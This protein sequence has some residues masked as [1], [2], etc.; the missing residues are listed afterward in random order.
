MRHWMVMLVWMMGCGGE[1]EGDPEPLLEEP[2]ASEEPVDEAPEG[3]SESPEPESNATDEAEPAD[4]VDLLHAVPTQLAASSAYRENLEQVSRLF[5]GDLETAWNSRTGDLETAWIEVLLPEDARVASIELTAGYT[6]VDGERDLFNGNHRIRRIR[7]SQNGAVLKEADL[8]PERRDLQPVDIGAGGGLYRITL[9]ELQPGTRDT[10]REACISELRF[11]GSAPTMNE[12]AHR[13]AASVGPLRIE[14]A[15]PD[16]GELGEAP[17][18]EPSSGLDGA[19]SVPSAGAHI[20]ERSDL[21]LMELVLARGVEDRAPVDPAHTFSKADD[22]QI[23]CYV[24]VA[25]PDREET[26]V[27]MQWELVERPSDEWGREQRIGGSPEW[28]TFR[29]TGTRRRAGRYRCVV[30]DDSGELLGQIAYDL[31]E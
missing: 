14:G 24:R 20:V 3:P 31:T 6:K 16:L 2:S 13:P 10:W 1:P 30:R 19:G 5:D 15:E 28:V 7:I 11:L 21:Q 26:V 25:N 18:P 27:Y 12:G 8:D 22:D 17:S 29:Y 23:Y 4:T 9:I